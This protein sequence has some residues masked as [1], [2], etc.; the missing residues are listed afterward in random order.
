MRKVTLIPGDGVGPEL[1]DAMRRC[2][3]ATGVGIE[4]EV[5]DAGEGVMKK[6]GTP[7]PEAVLNSIRK[8]RI[9]IKGPITTPIGSGF[10]SVNV[11]PRKIFSKIAFIY[12]YYLG[13]KTKV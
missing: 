3:D 8:N 9:A 10:R 7:L 6:E 5:L 12:A 2:V 13:F 4:W 11:A 1:S